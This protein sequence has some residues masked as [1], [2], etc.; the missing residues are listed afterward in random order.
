MSVHVNHDMKNVGVNEYV[1]IL[2]PGFADIVYLDVHGILAPTIILFKIKE[3]GKHCDRFISLSA[4]IKN[5]MIYQKEQ[6]TQAIS[7][8]F[9][10]SLSI[11]LLLSLSSFLS[12]M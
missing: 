3:N 6:N 8:P 5:K 11:P 7:P 1:Q 10:F 4:L 9:P 2:F 12:S